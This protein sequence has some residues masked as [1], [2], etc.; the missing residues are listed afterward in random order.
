[1]THVNDERIAG[2]LDEVA[3]AEPRATCRRYDSREKAVMFD[4]WYRG[5]LS[6]NE[7]QTYRAAWHRNQQPGDASDIIRMLVRKWVAEDA[8]AQLPAM[9]ET[10]EVPF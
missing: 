3:V 8:A 1:M 2:H 9:R 5:R 4:H 10:A 6:D 7:L